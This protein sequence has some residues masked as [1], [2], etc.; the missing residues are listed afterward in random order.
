MSSEKTNDLPL[1]H[2]WSF[3]FDNGDFS[4][5]QNND[6]MTCITLLGHFATVQSFWRYFNNLN[7]ALIIDAN[8]HKK[9]FNLR[10]FQKHIRPEWEDKHNIDGGK[11]MLSIHNFAALPEEEQTRLSMAL[12]DLW[13]DVLMAV[14]GGT[15]MN[16]DDVSGIILTSRPKNHSIQIWTASDPRIA[17]IQ[18]EGEE[19]VSSFSLPPSLTAASATSSDVRQHSVNNGIAAFTEHLQKHIFKPE[20]RDCFTVEFHSHRELYLN[21]PATTFSRLNPQATTKSRSMNNS[22]SNSVTSSPTQ[23]TRRHALNNVTHSRRPSSSG[24]ELNLRSLFINTPKTTP[25]GSP[26]NTPRG[27]PRGSLSRSLSTRVSHSHACGS[28]PDSVRR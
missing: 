26:F 27:T 20:L 1:Q 19:E 11:W 16:V 8:T 23:S 6:F 21:S 2:T 18:E 28:E 14:V 15:L 25:K 5:I 13:K 10:V 4:K 3:F 24:G 17:S 9:K 12:F 22:V 7:P